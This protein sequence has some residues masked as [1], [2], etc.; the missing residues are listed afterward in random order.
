MLNV[1]LN[2]LLTVTCPLL[3]TPAI[4]IIDA[5]DSSVEKA[6]LMGGDPSGLHK[7]VDS[8]SN[9]GS[10]GQRRETRATMLLAAGKIMKKHLIKVLEC[11][12]VV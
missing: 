6:T 7:K 3:Q 11:L 12:G 4:Q 2:L 10:T 5:D 9:T 1:N 8:L